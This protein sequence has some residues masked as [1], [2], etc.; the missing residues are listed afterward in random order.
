MSRVV[1]IFRVYRI[2]Y[3]PQSNVDRGWHEQLDCIWWREPDSNR[4]RFSTLAKSFRQLFSRYIQPLWALAF[5]VL[6]KAP[7]KAPQSA[8]LYAIDLGRPRTMKRCFSIGF[9]GV[10][11]FFSG[12]PDVSGSPGKSAEVGRLATTSTL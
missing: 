2:L 12:I 1:F 5:G 9:P 8:R 10:T 4:R 3:G 7:K 11:C 6:Q